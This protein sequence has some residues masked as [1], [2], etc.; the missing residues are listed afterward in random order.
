M[1]TREI[2]HTADLGIE[3]EAADLSGLFSEAA[4]A[5]YGLVADSDDINPKEKIA[6]SA[7]GQ[8]WEELFHAW[9]CELLAQFNLK[10]FVGKHCEIVSLMPERVEG[11]IRG[12]CLDLER[13]R[14]Y[15]EI[16]GVTYHHFKVW[17]EDGMWR[18]RVI[19]DV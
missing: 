9:L 12:E 10:G 3:I 16:K 17:Q 4:E 18:A 11:W 5:L 19:F 2:G 14:F 13:H 15:T 1:T 6:V 8:G 7:M